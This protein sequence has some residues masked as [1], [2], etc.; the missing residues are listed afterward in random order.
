VLPWPVLSKSK[1]SM[2]V[3]RNPSV[4]IGLT[5]VRPTATDKS[6]LHS[7]FRERNRTDREA[8][9]PSGDIGSSQERQRVGRLGGGMVLCRPC[10][11]V[12][13][14]QRKSSEV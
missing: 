7:T 6:K 2:K 5:G 9:V 13:A 12:N 3:P 8:Y 14:S 1:F 10:D 11:L 4:A